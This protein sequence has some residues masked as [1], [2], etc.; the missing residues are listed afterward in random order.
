MD[1]FQT[2]FDLVLLQVVGQR[3]GWLDSAGLV[4]KNVVHELRNDECFL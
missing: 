3:S 1:D 4:D 2:R